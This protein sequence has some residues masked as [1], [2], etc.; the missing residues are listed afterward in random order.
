MSSDATN[1]PTPPAAGFDG[2]V[3]Q[4]V[5][6]RALQQAMERDRL[7]H[8]LLLAGPEGIG[9]ATTALVLAQA[10]NCGAGGPRQACG[11]CVSCGKIARGLH[12]DVLWVGPDPKSIRVRQ[13]TPRSQSPVPAGQT[14][15]VF[16]GYTPYEGNRRVVVIDAA[17]T[18]NPEAQNALLKTLEE[19]PPSTT[20]V[21]VT[22]APRALLPTVLSRCQELRLSRIGRDALCAY[23]ETEHEMP[24]DEARLRA[25]LTPGS[26][27]KALAL[28]IESY[29]GVLEA[30]VEC[31]RMTQS[32]GGGVVAAAETLANLG[33]GETATQRAA[34]VLRV[35]RDVMR[36]LLVV[37]TG[38]NAD[39]VNAEQREAWVAWAAEV[40]S[41]QVVAALRAINDGIERFTTGIQPNIKMA[42][43]RTLVQVG[44]SLSP[45]PAS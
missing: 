35:A 5:V 1:L 29:T 34:S 39:L 17:H 40:D 32:G 31:L 27:G 14:V 10:L 37:S 6:I 4:S 8:A 30:V 15:T 11:T 16:V 18:M 33:D 23:L 12:P 38:A 45:G 41:E 24:A 21:L 9:K 20:L 26:I 28:D 22:A 7:H 44:E 36:D 19:P 42:F 25:A 43:E 13:I 3:G 2:I